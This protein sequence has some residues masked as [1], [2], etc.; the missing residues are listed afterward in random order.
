MLML[1]RKL[2][3]SIQIGPDITV[4]VARIGRSQIQ[5]GIQAPPD[6]Q[7]LRTELLE[8]PCPGEE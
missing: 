8:V 5:I 4:L 1:S 6:I 3:E 7:V 2:G